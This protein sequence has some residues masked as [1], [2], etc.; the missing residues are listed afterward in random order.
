MPHEPQLRVM[1]MPAKLW[2][3][4]QWALETHGWKLL[5]AALLLYVGR[6]HYR[7]YAARRHQQRALAAANGRC[8]WSFHFT[9]LGPER[10]DDVA[11]WRTM[12]SSLKL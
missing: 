11:G 8:L 6:Q 10:A 12:I 5:G 7:E 2:L 1:A 9:A 4:V 3:H